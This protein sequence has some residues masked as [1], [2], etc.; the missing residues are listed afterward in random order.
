M[1]NLGFVLCAMD[2]GLWTI[3]SVRSIL[4]IT[5]GILMVATFARPATA[6]NC[7]PPSIFASPTLDSPGGC[8]LSTYY[9]RIPQ[10][11]AQMVAFADVNGDGKQDM[12][13]AQA[14]NNSE[15]AVALGNG[16]GTFQA[17][18]AIYPGTCCSPDF[19]SANWV[20]VGDF[21]GDGKPDVALGTQ[22]GYVTILLGNGDGT[23]TLSQY[24]TVTPCCSGPAAG[25][26]G[27]FNGDG[28]LDL[29]VVNNT[30]N[31]GV[32]DIYL[33]NGNGTVSQSPVSVPINASGS[34]PSSIIV[35]DFNKDGKLDIATTDTGNSSPN[36]VSVA[37]GNGD[38]T[39]Q[40]PANYTLDSPNVNTGNVISIVS[41]DFNGDGYAD[42]VTLS[43]RGLME[44]LLNKGDGTFPATPTYY[45]IGEDYNNSSFAHM[46][47]VGDFNKDG[48]PDLVAVDNQQD[49]AAVILNNGDGTFG[50]PSYYVWADRSA[51][52]VA[53]VDTNGDGN[54][55]FVISTQMDDS[56]TIF[57]GNGDG[58][59]RGVRDYLPLTISQGISTNSPVPQTVAF[60]DFN[61]DGKMDMAV[62]DPANNAVTI[63]LNNGDGTFKESA[64]YSTGASGASVGV[65]DLNGDGKPD[66]V[67]GLNSN[68]GN[69]VGFGVLLGNGDG[70]FKP[71]V[72]YANSTSGGCSPTLALVDVNGDGKLDI[73][74]NSENSATNASFWVNLG[75]GDGTFQH[76]IPMATPALCPGGASAGAQYLLVKDLNGDGKPDIIG[77]C[78]IGQH[79]TY[80]SVLLG[81]GDGTFGTPTQVQVG[82]TPIGLAAGDFN[83][84]G[85]LD[86]VTVDNP[87]DE[88]SILLGNG[89]GTFKPAVSYST[90]SASFW[91][92]YITQ[93]FFNQHN[94]VPDAIAVGDFSGDG[95]LDVLVGD[96]SAWTYFCN[97][98]CGTSVSADNG[99]QLFLGNGDGT[100]QA[101]QSFL[102]GRQTTFFAVADLNGDGAADVAAVD[103]GENIVSIL[104]NQSVTPPV[105]N[106]SGQSLSFGNQAV[107]TTSVSQSATLSNTG[108]SNLA[109]YSISVTGTDPGDF[110]ETN[111]CP[112]ALAPKANCTIDVSFAPTASGARVASITISDN[113]S[114]GQQTISLSGTGAVPVVTLAPSGGLSFGSQPVGTT[115]AGQNIT[116]SNTGGVALSLSGITITG[117]NASDFKQTNTCGSSVV[118]G[119]FCTISVTFDP[120]A[121][122]DR[123]ASV[124][125]SDNAAGSPQS[126]ALSGTGVV[127]TVT[128]SPATGLSFGSQPV[129]IATSAQKITLTNTGGAS[130]SINSIT[131]TGANA[132]DFGETNTCGSSVAAGANCTISI[133]FT[134]SATG[135]RSASVSVSDSAAGSPQTAALS[136]TGVVAA[137]TLSPTSLTFSSQGIGTTSAAQTVTLTN[138]GGATLSI[139]GVSITGANAGD[140]A[141]TNTC[142]SSVAAG[143]NCS[144]SVTFTPGAS[145]ARNASL[146]IADNASGSPQTAALS[147]TGETPDFSVSTSPSAATVTAGS[148]AS[149]KITVT[150]ANGFNQ[151]VSLA[152][153][154]NP[155]LSSCAFNPNSLTPNG[156]AVSSTMSLS[157]TPTTTSAVM[158]APRPGSAAAQKI[159]ALA[160]LFCF[161]SL[162]GIRQYRARLLSA[163]ALLAVLGSVIACGGGG[164][165]SKTL[166]QGTPPG[167][168]TVTV[169]ATSGSGNS[170]L[171]H[172]TTVTLVVQ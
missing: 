111:N 57:L 106:L 118:A 54:P 143:A 152:C 127:A 11:N 47:A 163:V 109:I 149:Y 68:C 114:G 69:N 155:P 13:V 108:G 14:G 169:T 97:S 138:S 55:D 168:Y 59:F 81:K 12:I 53:V 87:A 60:G 41:A 80:F 35:G 51:A 9:F 67:V 4:P 19:R 103:P 91:Q 147:G 22:A 136:G 49:S 63:Y 154:G 167:T 112:A 76:G 56:V 28:K 37:F 21:N 132:G 24:L 117:T 99:L 33:G 140:F 170:A 10:A 72:I 75:N 101:A 34:E 123:S 70:T 162:G 164:S 26:V 128:L 161:F 130:L 58:T 158:P 104:L 153:S 166:N 27:D 17:S 135:A 96:Q 171:S 124:S 62:V 157:T 148:A 39:F 119:A 31:P 5:I 71:V 30:L 50:P 160:V 137:V 120:A 122:G 150:P 38:G 42:I 7:N 16:D 45:F 77:A 165:G 86:I 73:V 78:D 8:P 90:F 64:N 92:N 6:Q 18:I 133:N 105:A 36:I 20:V 84:D 85:K 79:Q 131:I 93:G 156:S 32:V 95:K 113:S 52:S 15:L 100:F 98:G 129:G 48:H 89:D 25:A 46:L 172:T 107:G 141:Q 1:K 2:R 142:G 146:S 43:N 144:I 134:P 23:F 159:I 110:K 139:T 102:A 3:S 83:G 40:T 121:A 115:S 44:V 116:L 126:V 65:G 125:I 145:G 151:A 66:L 88:F 61:A 82:T 74:A 94:P 29:A